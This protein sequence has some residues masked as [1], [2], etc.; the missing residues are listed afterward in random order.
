MPTR[1]EEII[2]LAVWRLRGDAYGVTIQSLVEEILGQDVSAG[3]VYVPLRRLHKRGYLSA[4]EGSPTSV[5]GGRR[6]RFYELSAKGV[7]ALSEAKAAHESAWTGVTLEAMSA[8][9]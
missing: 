6:K 4:H 9:M 2:L 7:R 1:I 3:T 5:R 8:G